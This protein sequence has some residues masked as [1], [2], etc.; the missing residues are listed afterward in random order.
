MSCFFVQLHGSIQCWKIDGKDISDATKLVKEYIQCSLEWGTSDQLQHNYI[1]IER[2][3]LRNE[4]RSWNDK[5]IGKL[6]LTV[7]VSDPEWFTP[8]G[9]S[10]IYTGALV[11]LY[12]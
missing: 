8:K 2:G 4:K 7:T 6:L 11:K 5:L 12:N 10:V 3:E 1:W 9:K